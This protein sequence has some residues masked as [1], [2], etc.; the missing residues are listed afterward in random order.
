[1]DIRTKDNVPENRDPYLTWAGSEIGIKTRNAQWAK[2][3]NQITVSKPNAK[4]LV[5]GGEGHVR[6]DSKPDSVS[7]LLQSSVKVFVIDAALM[8][9]ISNYMLHKM[10]LDNK[11]AAICG[12]K[13]KLGVDILIRPVLETD[14]PEE[15]IKKPSMLQTPSSN[16]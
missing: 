13:D 16:N 1:M 11:E 7:K 12:L 3:I 5:H 4:I 14:Y 9:T 6:Y 8:S 15:I 10:G 2:I